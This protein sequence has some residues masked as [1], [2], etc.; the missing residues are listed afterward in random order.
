MDNGYDQEIEARFEAARPG[1]T[2]PFDLRAEE[3]AYV[4]R[5]GG[6]RSYHVSGFGSQ[7]EYHRA[8]ADDVAEH[9]RL[10]HIQVGQISL[11]PHWQAD[12]VAL[13]RAHLASSSGVAS[14]R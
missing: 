9:V 12:Y 6:T 11:A 2:T 5:W 8:V 4:Y 3:I 14:G 10:G 1:S 13:V 7:E